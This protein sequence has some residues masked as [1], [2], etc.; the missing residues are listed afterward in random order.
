MKL[1][2]LQL[3]KIREALKLNAEVLR[4]IKQKNLKGESLKQMK[5]LEE[6]VTNSECFSICCGSSISR[7][8]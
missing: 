2:E 8:V 4:E 5:D 7:C 6:I 1:T 3:F